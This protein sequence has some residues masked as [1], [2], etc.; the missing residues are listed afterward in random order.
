MM[1]TCRRD[2]QGVKR[3]RMD[4]YREILSIGT[5]QTLCGDIVVRLHPIAI[6]FNCTSN[7]FCFRF[8]DV[9]KFT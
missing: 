4:M 1:Q 9:K 7:Q 2:Q 8:I 5:L 3:D 6:K